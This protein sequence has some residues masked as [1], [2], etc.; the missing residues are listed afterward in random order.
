[1]VFEWDYELFCFILLWDV[2]VAVGDMEIILLMWVSEAGYELLVDGE[3]VEFLF[4]SR[5]DWIIISGGIDGS[6]WL[7]LMVKAPYS[8]WR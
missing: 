4:N 1:M 2:V 7:E 5:G 8:G 3:R 6:R